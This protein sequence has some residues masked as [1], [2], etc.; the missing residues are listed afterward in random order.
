MQKLYQI[1]AR[2]F[3]KQLGTTSPNI[4]ETPTEYW[5]DLKDRGIDFVWLM[6][7]WETSPNSIDKYCFHPSLVEEYDRA[8]P[9]W[10]K[11]NV[12]GSPYAIE[13]YQISPLVGTLDDLL[14]A[15]SAINRAGLKLVLD[16]IPN[17]FNAESKLVETRPDLFFKASDKISG[18]P[19]PGFFERDNGCFANGRDPYFDPW[20]DTV[21][22]NYFLESTHEFMEQI[23]LNLCE[24]CDGV[25]CDMAMLVL[26]DIFQ[27]TWGHL[28]QDDAVMQNFWRRAIPAVKRK[29]PTF[30]FMAEV[31]WD[32][33]WRLQADGFD[34]T[35]DKKLLDL[36][37]EGNISAIKG[38]LSGEL[39]YHSKMVHFIENHDERRSLASFGFPKVMAAATVTATLPGM[40]LYFEGQWHGARKKLPV[41]LVMDTKEI[42]CPCPIADHS[43][44]QCAC[45]NKFYQQLLTATH[46]EVFD[47]GAWQL[48]TDESLGDLLAWKWKHQ[49]KCIYVFINLTDRFVSAQITVEHAH[50]KIP[51]DRLNNID[52]PNYLQKKEGESWSI[53]LPAYRSAIIEWG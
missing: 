4:A 24:I 1:N 36:M 23:L 51:S 47:K 38:H 48:C 32:T 15:K 5:K 30:L 46:H 39:S 16:F 18:Q 21:Q 27:N 37:L 8:N 53:Q 35:Y 49:A 26:P 41:Q 14:R 40:T 31:Y 12:G 52:R 19:S 45:I 33:E 42:S 11:K 9:E 34:Y 2:V 29:N 22:I 3:T 25:R 44:S 43:D 50:E 13:D 10:Q 20:T 28:K 6:G 17:H 7:V